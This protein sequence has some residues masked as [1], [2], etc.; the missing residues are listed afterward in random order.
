V[1]ELARSAVDPRRICFEITETAAMSKLGSALRFLSALREKGCRFA[2]DDFGSGLSSFAYLRH[3]PVD[4]L[5]ID[6]ALVQEMAEDRVKRAMVGAINEI[7]HVM[8]MRTIAEWVES[9]EV[10]DAVEELGVDYAQGFWFSRTQPL[11]HDH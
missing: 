11:I 10:L 4:F 3:L 6:G 8:G 1:A 2:L 9:R 5:K 7:G